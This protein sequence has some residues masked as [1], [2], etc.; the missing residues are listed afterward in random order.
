MANITKNTEAAE[1]RQSPIAA[2]FGGLSKREQVMIIVLV[3]AGIVCALFL[4]L[5][6]PGL[7]KLS[8]LDAETIKA[9]DLQA[10]YIDAI[11][12]GPAAA[13][14]LAAATEEYNTA[15]MR[16]FA[17]MNIE[18][19]DS[20]VTGYLTNA[21]FDPETLSMTP[22]EA[23]SL[24]RFT[25]PLAE[26]EVPPVEGSEAPAPEGEVPED[27]PDGSGEPAPEGEAAVEGDGAA[28]SGGSL[29]SY[30]VTTSVSGK[31]S[32]FYKLLD[33]IGATDGVEITQF[34]HT[35]DDSNGKNTFSMTIK[36]YV[37]VEEA[38]PDA[39]A[40][41]EGMPDAGAVEEPES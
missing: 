5:V 18:T 16:I 9:E 19:L 8:E 7:E 14:K 3:M 6:K 23:E 39:G 1:K 22:L 37:F 4:F 33:T 31:W 28:A 12:Q 2:A 40:A 41:E 11:A 24:G 27:Q 25:P 26:G 30:S 17:P 34:S 13:E 32:N 20:T 29:Y 36:F 38:L 10:E 15:R 35:S 21:G